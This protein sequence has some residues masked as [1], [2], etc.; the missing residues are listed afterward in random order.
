VIA[1][2]CDLTPL[3][4]CEGERKGNGGYAVVLKLA[5]PHV[6]LVFPY[7][8]NETFG[9]CPNL[10]ITQQMKAALKKP[11]HSADDIIRLSE[12]CSPMYLFN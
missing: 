8:L 7:A 4:F 10:L 9:P 11:V 2:G 1:L 3:V 12:N 6:H 5:T